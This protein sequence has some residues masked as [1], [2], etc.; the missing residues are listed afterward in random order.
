MSDEADAAAALARVRELCASGAARM[1]RE[2]NQLS[3]TETAAAVD[4]PRTTV[5]RWE[6]GER[7]PHGA[8]AVRYCEFLERLLRQAGTRRAAS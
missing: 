3:V 1:I 5:H 6:R 4:A 2:V 7:V 8:A